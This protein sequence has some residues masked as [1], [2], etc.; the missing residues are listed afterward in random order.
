MY[1]V[2][3]TIQTISFKVREDIVCFIEFLCEID[4]RKQVWNYFMSIPGH[5]SVMVFFDSYKFYLWGGVGV[6]GRTDTSNR[7]SNEI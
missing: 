6:G 1:I 3:K 5:K 2:S 4:G 7:K